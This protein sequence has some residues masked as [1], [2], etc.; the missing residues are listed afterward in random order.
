MSRIIKTIQFLNHENRI[1]VKEVMAIFLLKHTDG[2]VHCFLHTNATDSITSTADTGG[3][4]KLPVWNNLDMQLSQSLWVLSKS[5]LR[6]LISFSE[7]IRM[8]HY[9]FIWGKQTENGK[10]YCYL[11]WHMIQI[12]LKPEI[13]DKQLDCGVSFFHIQC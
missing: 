11:V 9:T 2:E 3:K 7:N 4:Y 10:I 5:A 1:I 8:H 12:E 6:F 13:P